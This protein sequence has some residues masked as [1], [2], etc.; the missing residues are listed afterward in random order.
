MKRLL[1]YLLL[2]LLN[3]SLVQPQGSDDAPMPVNVLT[4]TE[5][6]PSPAQS[7]PSTAG[8]LGLMDSAGTFTSFMEVP[9]QTSRL[10]P[11][12]D[13][14]LS[15]DGSLFAF[16]V[17]LDR[18]TLYLM[19]GSD[20]PMVLDDD[21]QGLACL[22]GGTFQFSPD[23]ARMAYIAYESDASASEFADGFMHVLDAASLDEQLLTQNVTAFDL[24]D[25]GLA[26]VSFFTNQRNEADEAAVTW[27]NG[28]GEREVATLRP[29]ENC[30]YTSASIGVMQD[31]SLLVVLGHRCTSGDTRTSWQ[32]YSVDPESRSA[33]LAASDFQPG[34]FAAY[35]R[36]NQIT[37]LPD[38]ASAL[39]TVPDGVTANTVALMQVNLSDFSTTE[40]LQR[41]AL[42]PTLNRGDNAFPQHS[43]DGRWLALVSTT[44]NAQN[45]LLVYD[46][47]D[48]SVAPVALS[49]GSAGDVIL[50]MAFS[51]NNERLFFLAGSANGD[52]SLVAVDLASGSDFRVKRGRFAPG[53]A[54]SPDGSSVVVMDW[55][56]L[57][58]ETQPPYLNT[59]AIDVDSGAETTLFE[60]AEIVD[61]EVT[62]Q[63]FARPI[64]WR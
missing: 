54:V 1:L 38:G 3:V 30:R 4:W 14:A 39:F 16:Y 40:L 12:G 46:L 31:A 17:G 61:G 9:A 26:Y 63:H 58:D 47:A 24:V 36:S 15:P 55:Q 34:Q 28:S 13:E 18:G 51:A 2:L 27:W 22:G 53:M 5:A 23:G 8:E 32:L 37:V 33:I 6:G 43:S 64:L 59:V 49:A 25:D 50:D 35:T 10:R 21:V 19:R 62:D 57:E 11:C 20:A 52:N 41:L 42:Y 29:D 44:P 45:T 60:G 56:V 48:L 7:S